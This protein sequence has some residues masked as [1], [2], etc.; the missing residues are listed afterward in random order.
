[1]PKGQMLS[2]E[3]QLFSINLSSKQDVAREERDDNT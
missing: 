1:M 3:M 2:K